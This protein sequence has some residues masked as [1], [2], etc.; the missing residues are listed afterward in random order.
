MV[1]SLLVALLATIV[2]EYGVLVLLRERRRKV[3]WAS[4]GVN[5]LTNV[6]LNLY[7]L[8]VDG[9]VMTVA[10][11]ELLVVAVEA[12]CYYG[13]M[14]RLSQ[15]VV[16]SVLCNAISFFTGLLGVL[17]FSNGFQLLVF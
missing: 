12:L 16:Y 6:P 10:I 9:S 13:L 15:A 4:V 1:L 17:V 2:I 7:L 5:V 3:L 11:G 14:K 8:L